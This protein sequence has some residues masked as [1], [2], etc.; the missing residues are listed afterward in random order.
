MHGVRIKHNHAD[1]GRF[2]DNL[3]IKDIEEKGQTICFCGVGAHHQN[4]IAEKRIGDLQRK[5]TTLLLHSQ[6]RWPD[7]INK[8]LWTYTIR[9]ANDSRNYS[10]TNEN[11]ICPMSRFCEISSVPSK[12]NQHYFGCPTYVLRKELQDQRKIRKWSARTRIGIKMDTHP[13]MH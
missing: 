1:N 4:G 3:F 7:A 10:P 5:A 13:G 8:H 9:V 6:R 11:G 12:K 2:E